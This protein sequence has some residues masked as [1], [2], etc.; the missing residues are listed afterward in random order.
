MNIGQVRDAVKA[1]YPNQSWSSQVDKMADDQ[2]TAIYLKNLENPK[3]LP[4]KEKP[5]AQGRLF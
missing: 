5:P 3:P 4:E 2:V 1:I